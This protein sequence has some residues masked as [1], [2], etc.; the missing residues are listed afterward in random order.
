[1]PTFLDLPSPIRQRIIQHLLN[2]EL[3]P[4][5]TTKQLHE[6]ERLFKIQRIHRHGNHVAEIAIER[7]IRYPF[8]VN[9]PFAGLLRTSSG[10]RREAK[11]VIKVL[12][13]K[14]IVYKLDLIVENEVNM[15]PVW[16]RCPVRAMEITRLDID[17]RLLGSIDD[18]VSRDVLD[19][20][21]QHGRDRCRTL[22]FA[23][24]ALI[25]RF[26]ERG[27][28]FEHL[29][30]GEIKVQTVMVNFHSRRED[31]APEQ[32]RLGRSN[33]VEEEHGLMEH[34]NLADLHAN[35]EHHH[36]TNGDA[37]SEAGTGWSDSGELV[38]AKDLL[39]T[40]DLVLRPLCRQEKY[41]LERRLRHFSNGHL[42]FLRRNVRKIYLT[43]DGG[44]EKAMMVES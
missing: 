27:P 28:R 34:L 5:E 41:T 20:L 11:D 24:V 36:M 33:S 38:E 19:G 9:L 14:R 39:R 43:L 7:C 31:F 30:Q 25:A 40:V 13:T 12:K 10:L 32:K 8:R 26:I 4:V 37:V 1:M 6:L 29:R 17:V 35:E 42:G 22:A 3:N 21:Q 15:L 23:I 18:I 2:A 44:M 16:L